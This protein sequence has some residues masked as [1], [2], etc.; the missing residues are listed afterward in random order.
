MLGTSSSAG[1]NLSPENA[2]K[3]ANFHLEGARKTT[4]PDLALLLYKEAEMVLARMERSTTDSLPRT[5]CIQD[6]S[7]LDKMSTSSLP[8]DRLQDRYNKVKNLGNN[9]GDVDPS[10]SDMR[11]D[12]G[13]PAENATAVDS[14]TLPSQDQHRDITMLAPHIFAENKQP[15][16]TRFKLPEPDERLQDI[17]QLTY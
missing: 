5:D 7:V 8:H 14:T 2:K 15:P 1:D 9:N 4:D 12:G 11:L 17:M 10:I 6:Q 3:L 16:V 13:A